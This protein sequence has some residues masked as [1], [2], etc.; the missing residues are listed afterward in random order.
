M[1]KQLPEKQYTISDFQF[2]IYPKTITFRSSSQARYSLYLEKGISKFKQ[3][4]K[5]LANI[6]KLQLH[7]TKLSHSQLSKE[8]NLEFLMISLSVISGVFTKSQIKIKAKNFCK[9]Q[10]LV[11]KKHIPHIQDISIKLNFN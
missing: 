5:L 3:V 1:K 9:V 8:K 2:S 7:K 4:L 10:S 6:N 11:Y